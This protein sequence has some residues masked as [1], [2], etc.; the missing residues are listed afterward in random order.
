MIRIRCR[1]CPW[2]PVRFGDPTHKE[3]GATSKIFFGWCATHLTAEASDAG[4]APPPIPIG[5][6]RI[7]RLR[8]GMTY[9]EYPC[10]IKR[11]KLVVR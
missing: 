5:H 9:E 8:T 1:L 4:S 7:L 2:L 6:A 3:S 11:E 10:I